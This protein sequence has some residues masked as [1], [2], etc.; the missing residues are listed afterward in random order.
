MRSLGKRIGIR[1][2]KQIMRELDSSV[3]LL[4]KSVFVYLLNNVYIQ[5]FGANEAK[6]WTMAV[7]STLLQTDPDNE[8]SR[9]FLNENE[10]KIWLEAL[11]VKKHPDLSGVSGAASYLYFAEICFVTD[12]MREP[13]IEQTLHDI[14]NRSAKQLSMDKDFSRRQL[15]EG[16]HN[17]RVIELNNRAEQLGIFIPTARD[18]C[19]SDDP[20][21]IIES[22]CSFAN[23][24]FNKNI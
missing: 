2:K 13:N 8:L 10:D 7:L 4:R 1:D 23:V 6:H 18:I 15:K 11:Q 14:I 19:N 21:N 3:D 12:M 20:I 5:K 24:F 22:I 17:S 16:I 9:L